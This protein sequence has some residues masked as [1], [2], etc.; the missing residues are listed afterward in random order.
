[1]HIKECVFSYFAVFLVGHHNKEYH[2]ESL[3]LYQ[4]HPMLKSRLRG[5][6]YYL[7]QKEEPKK[8]HRSR[9]SDYIDSVFHG[10]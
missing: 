2:L 1:M 4:Y 6:R 8:I 10:C 5:Q 9:Y 7:E 3:C